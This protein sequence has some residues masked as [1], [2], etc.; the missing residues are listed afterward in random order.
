MAVMVRKKSKRE[1]KGAQRLAAIRA[2]RGI[3]RAKSVTPSFFKS[4][5]SRRAED[6]AIEKRHDELLAS[7]GKNK[8]ATSR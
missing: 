1:S 5:S 4:V 6:R 7:I 2:L 8:P 3:L